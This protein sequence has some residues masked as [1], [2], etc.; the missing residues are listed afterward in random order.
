V[1]ESFEYMFWRVI[2]GTQ[3]NFIHS[4][5]IVY[6][7]DFIPGKCG[8][9]PTSKVDIGPSNLSHIA[10]GHVVSCLINICVYTQYIV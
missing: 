9:D 6:R 7:K 3:H 10:N 2:A 8:Q 5:V 4:L 1:V